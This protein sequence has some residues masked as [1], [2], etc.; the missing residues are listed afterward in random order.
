MQLWKT[1]LYYVDSFDKTMLYLLKIAQA[2]F[3]T[4]ALN[5]ENIREKN[6]L[7]KQPMFCNM[8][9]EFYLLMNQGKRMQ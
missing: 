5:W 4:P 1:W 6:K 9:N 3:S 2:G 8:R 7:G